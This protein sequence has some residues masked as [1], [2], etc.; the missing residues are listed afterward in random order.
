MAKGKIKQKPEGWRSRIVGEGDEA[1]DQLLANPWQWR[2]HPTSQ[3]DALTGVLTEIRWV[4]RV[5]VN[6]QTQHL[7]D[8]HARV[9]VAIR[10]GEKSVP[11][12]YVDLSEAEEKLVLASIDPL[13]AL[14]IADAQ[15]LDEL[16]RDV[17][18]GDSAVQAMLAELAREAGLYQDGR[19]AGED[20]GAQVDKA[21]ELREKWQTATGQLWLI[22]SKTVL[23]KAHRLL[24]GDSTSAEDVARLMAGERA[25]LFATDPPYGASAGNIGFTAQRDDVEAITNDD[26]TNTDM[27]AWLEG[28]FR[29]WVPRLADNAAWYL[30]HPMLTQGYFA[31]AAA[32]AAAAKV[33]IHRQ[34]I[35]V[36]EQF[37]FGRG[38]YHWQHEL[39]FYGW[40]QGNRPPFYGERN[41][42]TIW[43]VPWGVKR[44]V[45]GHP[46]AKP[47][48]LWDAPMRNHTLPGQL[49]AEPFAGSGAQFAAGE[50]NGRL[51]YGMELEPKYIAVALERLSGLGLSPRLA[52][53]G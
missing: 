23:G 8:G 35:W 26:L 19:G 24:C 4:Q 14:A 1:P 27:Q 20:P 15:K 51:V 18:T 16:L 33:V 28:V 45:I 2:I 22:P 25:T 40:R 6:R 37:I 31:A 39:C 41:Q 36:K 47:P 7:V 17:Q 46:T 5:I 29:V 53:A 10:R 12:L 43:N 52:E 38:D 9:A 21:E 48:A 30:W 34:I 50:Q 32:A 3:Q 11:V 49:C 44:S 42:A 13:S